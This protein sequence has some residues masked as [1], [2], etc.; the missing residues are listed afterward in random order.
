MYNS[1]QSIKVS[2]WANDWGHQFD[3]AEE[4]D[5]ILLSNLELDAWA[6]QLRGQIGRNSRLDVIGKSASEDTVVTNSVISLLIIV[7]NGNIRSLKLTTT[8]DGKILHWINA[9]RNFTLFSKS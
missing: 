2:G 7:D 6:N 1:N 4:G 8:V 5:F 3:M 9:S